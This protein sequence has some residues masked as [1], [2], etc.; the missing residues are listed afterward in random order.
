MPKLDSLSGTGGD[1]LSAE[2][3]SY[4]ALLPAAS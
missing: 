1:A 2:P 3:T 4:D